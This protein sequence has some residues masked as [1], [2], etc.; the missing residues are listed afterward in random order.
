[1]TITINGDLVLDEAP[2][3]DAASIDDDLA[4][5]TFQTALSSSLYTHLF[6]T[7]G[8]NLGLPANTGSTTFPQV[9]TQS[10]F[11]SLDTDVDS[12]TLTTKDNLNNFVSFAGLDSGLTDLAGHKIF[13]YGDSGDH[14]VLGRVST[15]GSADPNGAV[16][17]AIVLD[18]QM[19][20][21]QVHS[22]NLYSLQF[23][24]LKN[25]DGSNVD[26]LDPLNLAGANMYLNSAL[27]SQ[28]SFSD[29]SAVPSGQDNWVIIQPTGEG[30]TDPDILVTGLL[31]SS[32][33]NVST[34][35]LGMNSQAVDKGELLRFD[36]V[37]GGL[38][39]LT[40]TIVH[41]DS[42]ISYA[43]HHSGNGGGF[44]L[45]Q[46]SPN[47]AAVS[48]LVHAYSVP[49]DYT[50]STFKS[51]LDEQTS[52]NISG[53][54]VFNAAGVLQLDDEG[55]AGPLS[56]NGV[57]IN[58]DGDTAQ[59]DGLKVGYTVDFS[60]TSDM[61]RFTVANDSSA[62]AGFDLGAIYLTN[63]QVSTDHPEI[64]SHLIFEDDGPS[65]TAPGTLP[66]LTVDETT[67]S[68]DDSHSFAGVFTALGGADG[69]AS[70]TY[71]L[72][73]TAGPS[74]L[75]DTASGHNVVLSVSGGV[76]QGRTDD[77]DHFLVFQVSV[78]GSGVVT[79]DQQRAVA[80]PTAGST[81][82][83]TDESIS[84]SAADLIKLTATVT[85]GDGDTASAVANIGQQL[86]FKDDGPSITG[87][88][89][90]LSLTVDETALS[91]DATV[92]FAGAFTPHGGADG[93][94]S[95][96]YALGATA[97]ASGLVDTATGHNV[98]LSV[99]GSGVVEGRTDDA[100]HLLVFTVS[101]ASNG[102]VTL[103]QLRAIVHPTVG[104]SSYDETTTLSGASL[105]T[106]TATATDGDGDTAAAT[107]NI[108]QKLVFHDDGPS[109]FTPVA[110]V[111]ADAVQDQP[112]EGATKDLTG[113]GGTV[114]ANHVGADG[115][116][117]LV[118]SGTDGSTLMG[119]LGTDTTTAP[120]TAHGHD[121]LLSGFGGATLTGYTEENGT[122][123][124]QSGAGGDKAIFTITLNPGADTYTFAML[125]QI[126]NHASALNVN[127]AGQ[128]QTGYEFLTLDN[129]QA[130]DSDGDFMFTG[131][132]RGADGVSILNAPGPSAKI[133]VSSSGIGVGSQSVDVH[134]GV[135]I[136]FVDGAP[137]TPNG[138][139]PISAISFGG[140]FSHTSVNNAGIG[141]SQLKPNT[142]TNID[143]RL[144]AYDEH[145][146]AATTSA[147]I[148]NDATK[149]ITQVT[150]IAPDDTA[151][152]PDRFSF[153]ADGSHTLE[154]RAISVDFAP[155]GAPDANYV[156]VHNM[157][158]GYTVLVS[159]ADG[160]ERLLVE[161]AGTAN[162]GFD[163]SGVRIEQFNGGDQVHF[164][165]PT[166][167]SDGD[168]DTALGT[169]AVTLT[170]PDII[171]A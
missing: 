13:L 67:L 73:A 145:V 108:G 169:I 68:T 166:V 162:Q 47:K 158:V 75:V 3:V 90:G 61:N 11:I 126:D 52:V 143:M 60:T 153:S 34:T 122:A 103:D 91:T 50:P 9:A 160:F 136:D 58:L 167:V 123:G 32:T 37:D 97:G 45:T 17:V 25:P 66:S 80:H 115:Y 74:G 137:L 144:S 5:A 23:M 41:S 152:A 128:K 156:D 56:G 69:V 117:S 107:V 39:P 86:N 132:M 42:N 53:V 44:S 105:V 28:T 116:K 16:A 38:T 125:D 100:G 22:A 131:M 48:T 1:M 72:S 149:P 135:Y 171:L 27:T 59:I 129:P 98:V 163:I 155:A 130:A 51:H 102:D 64:G 63:T 148:T 154:G 138:Q 6:G 70:T 12:L 14:V 29:F 77:A 54:R 10:G 111:V 15:G 114:E 36:F 109:A 21:A 161:N 110:I 7:G 150:V 151:G 106:L 49:D 2:G 119:T 170:A 94:A 146:T 8:S 165:V 112:G 124:Y 88:A 139:T 141:I 71:A 43:N 24:A 81:I 4:W 20:G 33:V 83:A 101:V 35:G 65:I 40:N 87:D 118:F 104:A 159:T 62:K 120:L 93:L 133:A 89:T 19:A 18:D 31:S 30:P 46:T 95:T 157:G 164:S 76:V 168:N 84:L 134:D 147:N 26:D 92:S 96:T 78:D 55:V 99:N 121:V 85:D 79:L 142:T 57:T 113:D 82:A 140:A 127:F